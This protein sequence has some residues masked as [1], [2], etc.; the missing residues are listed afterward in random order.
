MSKEKQSIELPVDYTTL[1]WR[2]GETRAVR[3]EYV[4][5]QAGRCFWCEC[6]LDQDPPEDV[7]KK[8]ID[9]TLFPDNFLRH[10]VHLQHDHYTNMTEGSVHA[11]CNAVMWQYHGR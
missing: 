1:D 9:W 10:P 6:P 8:S 11:Y 7:T 4:R 5:R 3:E 2:K